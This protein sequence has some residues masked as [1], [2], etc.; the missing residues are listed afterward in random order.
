[1]NPLFCGVYAVAVTPFQK[2][3]T[4]DYE[5]AKKNLDWLIENGVQGVCILGATGEYQSISDEEHM[6]Y[7]KEI[8]PYIKDRTSVIVGASRERPEDVVKL[9]KNIKACGAHA[10]MVL[11]SFYC[12]PAQDEIV[13]HY[14]YI[15]EQT[16]FPIVA[17]NNPGSAGIEIGQEAF[18]KILALPY[19]AIVKESSGT[20]QKLTEVL[21]DAPKEVSVFCGCDNLAYE[22]FA[23]GACGWISML[24][25][26]APRQCV[27]LY[28][29]VCLEKD[30]EKGMQIYKE[31]LPA[32]NVLESFPK[33]VQALKYG[34]G[35]KGL[36]G[37]F[38]R[39]PRMELTGEEKSYVERAMQFE[40]LR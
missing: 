6:E 8:V 1:M 16:E 36:N 31:I 19:T 18:R 24:A 10:A 38:V 5:S 25:N 35:K 33:P 22:S 20:M 12:H 4:F 17:Y 3:G 13:E 7:V 37:G 39:R 26:V 14:R 9:V 23:D 11:P 29:S 30:L 34:L 2:D 40:K 32:L 27:E 15:E 28:R 21:L